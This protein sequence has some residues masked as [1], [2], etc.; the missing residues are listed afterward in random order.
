MPPKERQGDLSMK[1]A[2]KM[3]AIVMVLGLVG[4]VMAKDPGASKGQGRGEHAAK[5][6][7]GKIVRIDG[8]SVVIATKKGDEKVETPVA[9]N[10]DTKITI[11]GEAKTIGDLKPGMR[12]RV[13]PETGIATE[14]KAT[15][16]K[17][18]EKHEKKG[19]KGAAP[20]PAP[21]G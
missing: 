8:D 4:T 9:T 17:P 2:M 5:G 6:L 3:L 13:E 21:K 10:K 1:L 18:E 15:T 11:D 14:I 16:K 20:A 19:D 12:V 7:S